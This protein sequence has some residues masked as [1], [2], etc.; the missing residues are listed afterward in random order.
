M[1]IRVTC[2][3]C[4]KRFYV[5]PQ[6]DNN[7]RL[8]DVYCPHCTFRF[9]PDVR[10]RTKDIPVIEVEC[11]A[12]HIYYLTLPEVYPS[13]FV[14]PK[15]EYVAPCPLCGRP[16]RVVLK[17]LT[18]WTFLLNPRYERMRRGFGEYVEGIETD[19]YVNAA[20][21]LKE[22]GDWSRF[23]DYFKG[24]SLQKMKAVLNATLVKSG[25]AR[26]SRKSP[27]WKKVR[28]TL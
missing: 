19:S 6:Y 21:I 20:H 9:N 13:G 10:L 26:F 15:P 1:L 14:A 27:A 3:D 25:Y 23:D 2:I 24:A 11:E 28:Q 8:R 17:D 18:N 16:Y 4:G 7:G 5:T 22:I 12:E